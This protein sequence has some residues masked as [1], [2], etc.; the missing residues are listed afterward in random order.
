FLATQHQT[1]GTSETQ[2]MLQALSDECGA[3][4]LQNSRMKLFRSLGD[5]FKNGFFLVNCHYFLMQFI[6][7]RAR[8]SYLALDSP[9]MPG[10][11][12]FARYVT[13]SFP[14]LRPINI[15]PRSLISRPISTAIP[16]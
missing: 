7:C 3:V 9:P 8:H 16:N 14:G 5:R 11:L 1:T 6:P 10:S 4:C 2:N 12:L 13:T 15:P